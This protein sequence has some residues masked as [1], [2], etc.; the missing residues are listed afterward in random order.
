MPATPAASYEGW[1]QYSNPSY[2]F[3]LCYPPDWTAE[4]DERDDST[5]REHLLWLRP[6]A[7]G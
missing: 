2:G 5:S 4:L 1:L 7:A 3:A 6:P